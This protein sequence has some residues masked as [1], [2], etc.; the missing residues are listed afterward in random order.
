MK[1]KRLFAFGC[2]FTNYHWPT[3]ADIVAKEHNYFENWG[4]P[5][6]GNHFIF[7]SLLECNQRNKFTKDDTVM[8]CWS[9]V[10]R[11]DRYLTNSW[12]SAGNIFTTSVYPKTWVNEFV[13]ERGCLIRDL[14]FIKA[15]NL[16]LKNIGCNYKFFSIVPIEY[17]MV[18]KNQSEHPDVIEL[19]SDVIDKISP[20]YFEI[21]FNFEWTSR[22]SNFSEKLIKQKNKE[23]KKRYEFCAGPDWPTFNEAC[24]VNWYKTHNDSILNE[25][26]DL[27]PFDF[28]E[29]NRDYHPTP[30]EHLEY[31]KKILPEHAISDS[32]VD[33]VRNYKFGD[34]FG[35]QKIKRL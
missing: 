15:I 3:W 18:D 20:S 16:L 35:K 11:E 4:Q 34:K 25:I 13:T 27:F 6:C 29:T 7:N 9:N 32:T 23:F 2:S 24:N 31:I 5:G 17:N 21:I 19:Y 28:F 8:I 33:W 14:A 12:L 22:Y 30:A 26:K 1:N 10:T